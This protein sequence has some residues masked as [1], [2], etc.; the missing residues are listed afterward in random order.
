MPVRFRCWWWPMS[1]PTLVLLRGTAVPSDH[2]E[3]PGRAPVVISHDQTPSHQSWPTVRPSR[4]SQAAD[5]ACSSIESLAPRTLPSPM[6]TL[7]PPV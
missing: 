3:P 7:M 6:V 5:H 4:G 2:S 1:Q